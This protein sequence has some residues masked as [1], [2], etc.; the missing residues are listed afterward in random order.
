MQQQHSHTEKYTEAH[1][2]ISDVQCKESNFDSTQF[3]HVN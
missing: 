3:V 2:K 1:V